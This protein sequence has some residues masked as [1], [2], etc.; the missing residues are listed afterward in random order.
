MRPPRLADWLLQHLVPATIRDAIAGDL[1]EQFERRGTAWY[2]RQ[3]LRAIVAGL[4]LELRRECICFALAALWL[5][6]T[7][8][9]PRQVFPFFF[10]WSPA[11]WWVTL[12]WPWSL[13]AEMA[14]D[15]AS[16]AV[17]LISGI[18]ACLALT[19]K[20]TA[21]GYF[22]A[23]RTGLILLTAIE[24]TLTLLGPFVVRR[25]WVAYQVLDFLA[26]TIAL[27]IGRKAA[28]VSGAAIRNP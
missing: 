25:N 23:V 27:W 4:W 24:I 16:P 5:G 19:G 1:L 28:P 15:I 20:L 11:P 6:A 8:R 9:I 22:R 21:A 17:L 3:T 26:F 13:I 10:T 14:V 2:W 7:Q 18:C 12:P